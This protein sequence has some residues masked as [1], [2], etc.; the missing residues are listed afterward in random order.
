M[1]STSEVRQNLWTLALKPK[2]CQH[3]STMLSVSELICHHR[4]LGYSPKH[5][6]PDVMEQVRT[7]SKHSHHGVAI[8]LMEQ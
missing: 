6:T 4:R 2:G 8:L 3:V 1:P 7:F 5:S